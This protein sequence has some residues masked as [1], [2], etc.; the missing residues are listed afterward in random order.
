MSGPRQGRRVA[1]V[2]RQYDEVGVG[3]D[4]GGPA[5]HRPA[6]GEGDEGRAIAQ[7]VGVG[8]HQP[9]ANHDAAAAPAVPPDA[10]DR[11]H[12]VL[13]DPAHGGLQFIGRRHDRSS[14]DEA[15]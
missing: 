9:F 12:D 3:I 8:Q 7:V 6:V 5:L 11:G 4:A 2:D 13:G 15:P 10:D 14:R 1:G